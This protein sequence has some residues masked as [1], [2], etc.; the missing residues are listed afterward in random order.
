MKQ[1]FFMAGLPRAGSTLLSSI[2]N[3]NPSIYS[4]ASSPVLSLMGN[5][6]H[7]L[8]NDEFF[9][10]NPKPNAAKQIISN[11]ID[12]YYSDINKPIV[13]DKNR[14]WAYKIDYIMGYLGQSPKIIC[15]VRNLD[16]ILASFISLHR[17][18]QMVTSDGK[19]NFM[20]AML[21][22]NNIPL[23]DDNRC[24]VLAS[25]NGVVGGSYNNMKNALT[26]GYQKSLHFVEYDDL[27]TDTEGTIKRLYEFLELPY[28]EHD[29]SNIVNVNQER[30]VE[31]YGFNDMHK[32]RPIIGKTSTPPNEILSEK[33]LEGCK[34]SEFWRDL[35][36][37]NQQTEGE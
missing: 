4:S 16:E 6:E 30:D 8:S 14:G 5:I 1:Y 24:E 25:S 13:I 20:D 10:A 9:N 17:R 23:N 35:E 27:T 26:S 36:L 12:H 18:H 28:Y 7:L 33:I 15:P 2:L 19:V 32:V 11:I 34:G 3:Q 31:I 21:I 37:F 22:K 29:Y